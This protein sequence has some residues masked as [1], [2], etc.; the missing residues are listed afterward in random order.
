MKL[1]LDPN[2][3]I[4]DTGATGHAIQNP[5]DMVKKSEKKCND[6]V[7]MGNGKSESTEWHGGLPVTLCDGGQ[8]QK[9]FR[10]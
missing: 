7:A 3:W 4:A 8:C 10:K 6:S 9:R 1:L 2:A 5:S